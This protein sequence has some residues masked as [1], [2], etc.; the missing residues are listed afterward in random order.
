MTAHIKNVTKYFISPPPFREPQKKNLSM[1]LSSRH[2][3]DKS[4]RL[5]SPHR[6]Q[7]I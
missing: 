5:L 2:T 4:L 1:K 6:A 7:T 3:H